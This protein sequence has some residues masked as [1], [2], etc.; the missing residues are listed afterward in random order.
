MIVGD[1]NINAPDSPEIP[2]NRKYLNLLQQYNLYQIVSKST[3]ITTKYCTLIDHIIV[4]HK[5]LVKHTDVLPCST[6]N[7]HDGPYAL[8]NV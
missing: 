8:L 7:D 1:T 5:D 6:I 2:D 3:R 4:S